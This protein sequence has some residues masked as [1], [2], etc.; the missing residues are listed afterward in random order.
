VG[1]PVA[2]VLAELS[3]RGLLYQRTAESELDA[4]LARPG[5]V[6]YC[7]FDPTADSLT[8]GNLVPLMLLVHW[9][10]AGHVPIALVGGGTGLIGDPSERDAERPLLT[11][12]EVE[13]NVQGQKRIFER[14]LDLGGPSPARLLNNADWLGS[15]G[16]LDVLRNVGKHFSVNAMIQREAIRA[17]LEDR[18]QGISYTE[19]SYAILQAYDFLHLHREH[20]CTVQLSGSDQYGNVVSGIDL[21][22]RSLGSEAEAFGLTAPLVTRSDGKKFS[23]SE[24]NAIW[25]TADRTSPYAFHQYWL[26]VPDAEA[27]AFLRIY[28]LLS[29]QEIEAL[30]VAQES[31]PHERPA[32]RALARAVTDALHGEDERQRV[33]AA[34]EALFGS[35][36]PRD[37]DAA[38]LA[39]VADELPS[40]EHARDELSGEGASLV[41]VLPQTSLA[42]SKRE[43]REFLEKGAISVNGRRVEA[44]WRLFAGDLLAGGAI[45]LRRGKKRWHATHWK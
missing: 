43:A 27:V 22:H 11:R 3:W 10:R 41:E 20:G 29:R 42:S 33:E 40:S 35:G 44:P 8:Q 45:L 37:I 6:G 9:Q 23:K 34:G 24:G 4:H 12:D 2:P 1:D 25:L 15:L 18:S 28:T 5:R 7:G 21:I 36:D 14:L 31:A 32:Q 26:N 38:T 30:G 17:R 39:Q 16:Y 13:A 19:F